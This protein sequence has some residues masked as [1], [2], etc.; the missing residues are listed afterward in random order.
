MA[1]EDPAVVVEA[2]VDRF[3]GVARL[4]GAAGLERLARAHVA[5][6]GVGGVGSWAVEALA[7]SGVG[8]L[9]L[10]DADDVCVTNVNRQLPAMD[11]T[12]GRPKVEVLAERVAAIAPRCRVEPV[13]AFF[14]A[15][16]A[17]ELFERRPDWIVDAIDSLQHKVALVAGA[18]ARGV[19]V[20]VTGG[21]GGKRDGTAVRVTDLARS[22][23]DHLLRWVRKRLRQRHGFPRDP[24]VA[25]GIPCVFSAEPPVFP[26]ADGTCRAVAEPGSDPALSCASGYGTAA[27]VTGAFGFAAAGVVVT[28]VAGGGVV[29]C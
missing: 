23:V 13:A 9:T 3:G 12:V 2:E 15:E 14:T 27:F 28:R 26:W 7:R 16:R 20:V 17:G 19:G 10:V 6:V 18:H 25:F 11:G 21:T 8:A 29:A 22:E 1:G 24:E 4:Y 5:V